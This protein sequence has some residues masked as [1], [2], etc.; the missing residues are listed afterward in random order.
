MPDYPIVCNDTDIQRVC[1]EARRVLSPEPER[2][3]FWQVDLTRP[4]GIVQVNKDP[5]HRP[6]HYA[7]FAIEPITFIMANNIGFAAGNVIKY[8]M[9]WD[10][11]DGLQDL[12]K[13]RRYI[14]MMIEDAERKAAG[15]SVKVEAL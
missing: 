2:P 5:V 3:T 14:D 6:N 1:D 8:V 11:K 4:D 13:A 9:R 10:A 12:K 7:R 15:T